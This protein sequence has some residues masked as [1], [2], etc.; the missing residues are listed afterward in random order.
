MQP[1]ELVS[2]WFQAVNNI[3]EL[4]VVIVNILELILKNPARIDNEWLLVIWIELF[5][6]SGWIIIH[7]RET[8]FGI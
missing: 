6:E 4:N 7:L 1:L 3:Q 8:L 5:L 2:T